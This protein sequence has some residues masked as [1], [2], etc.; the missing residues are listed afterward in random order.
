MTARS[1]LE[2]LGPTVLLGGA[3]KSATTSMFHLLEQHPDI[4]APALKEP[5]YFAFDEPRRWT[6]P[7][8]DVFARS[9]VSDEADYRALFRGGDRHRHRLEA[10]TLYLSEP[11]VPERVMEFDPGMKIIF[12]LRDP[13]ERT[14]SA[15]NFCRLRGWEDLP[16]VFDGIAAEE[17]RLA[18]GWPPHF[19]YRR[20]SDYGDHLRRWFAVFPAEQ[21]LCLSK[22]EFE[23]DPERTVRRIEAFL[24]LERCDG[25]NLGVRHNPSGTPRFERFQRVIDSQL[26]F[27]RRLRTIAPGFVHRAVARAREWNVVPP[28]GLS[29]DDRA[30]LV[31]LFAG[32]I[33]IIRELAGD[34]IVAG[35]SD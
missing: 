15:F 8:S 34:D 4:H 3:Q 17:Q 35:W 14:Y 2:T 7:G 12:V 24:D 32:Q 5:Q 18:D 31:E 22:R 25:Y 23:E 16:T 33:E 30:R 9:V 29:P 6:G 10:S 19:G 26:A 21:I 28:D 20:L 27:K 13:A 11:G 1:H